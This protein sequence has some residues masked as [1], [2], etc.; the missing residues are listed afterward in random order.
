MWALFFRRATLECMAR[1]T[2]GKTTKDAWRERYYRDNF[3]SLVNDFHLYQL[4]QRIIELGLCAK[5]INDPSLTRI[6]NDLK[7]CAAVLLEKVVNFDLSQEQLPAN[8]K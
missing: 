1:K 4:D 8:Q 2:Q 6:Y 5:R 3:M 7:L